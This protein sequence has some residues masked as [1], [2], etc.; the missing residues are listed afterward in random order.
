MKKKNLKIYLLSNPAHSKRQYAFDIFIAAATFN[1]LLRPIAEKFHDIINPSTGRSKY[2]KGL[3]RF[4]K[5]D[6]RVI[7]SH[8]KIAF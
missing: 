7:V 1:A 5:M 6:M 8:C 3:C 4:S 2:M